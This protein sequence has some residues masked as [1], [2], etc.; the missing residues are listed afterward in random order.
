MFDQMQLSTLHELLTADDDPDALIEVLERT[1]RASWTC[2]L[3][4]LSD[5]EGS[6]EREICETRAE[7]V[8]FCE[9]RNISCVICYPNYPKYESSSSS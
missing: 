4:K 3:A 2:S 1:S 7:A 5:F 8:K 6:W 9:E